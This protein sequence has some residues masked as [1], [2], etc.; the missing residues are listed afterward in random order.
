[1]GNTFG[2]NEVNE[3]NELGESTKP[4]IDF[5]NMEE[6]DDRPE[7]YESFGKS[8]AETEH[9]S[10]LREAEEN[11]DDCAAKAEK[12]DGRRD[13]ADDRLRDAS[14]DGQYV[15]EVTYQYDGSEVSDGEARD[16]VQDAYDN[17]DDPEDM[18]QLKENAEAG[19][20]VEVIDAK[21][22]ERPEVTEGREELAQAEQ[23]SAEAHEELDAA[24]EELARQQE[25][26]AQDEAQEQA[27]AQQ[28]EVRR[29]QT[30][31]ATDES[32]ENVEDPAETGEKAD[33]EGI[34]DEKDTESNEHITD[35]EHVSD[36]AGEGVQNAEGSE[37][38]D[39]EVGEGEGDAEGDERGDGE[40]GE[41]EG[42]A[43]GDE[44]ADGEV[45]EDERDAEGDERGDG[46]VGEGD[47][48]ADGEVGESERDAEGDERGD[49]EVGESERDAEGD[50]RAD[51]EVGEGERDA[52]G[53]ER[54]DGEVGE[55]E[56]DAEG[57][58]RGDGEVGEGERD[59]EGDERGDGEVGEGERDAE[60]DERGD[61]EVGEGE[62]DAEGENDEKTAEN[63]EKENTDGINGEKNTESSPSID[64]IGQAEKAE[65]E[66][67]GDTPTENEGRREGTDEIADDKEQMQK[68]GDAEGSESAER[69][70]EKAGEGT[71]EKEPTTKAEIDSQRR[72]N[73]VRLAQLRD[74]YAKAQEVSARKFEDA[75][76]KEGE[77]RRAAIGVFNDVKL[78][79]EQIHEQIGALERE[80][81]KLGVKSR[82]VQQR[83]LM[84]GDAALARSGQLIDHANEMDRAF[85]ETYYDAKAHKGDLRQLRE[86]NE[87]AID[88]LTADKEALRR[89]MDAKMDQLG[90]HI[91]QNDMD[92]PTS[93]R[94]PLCQQLTKEYNELKDAYA[95]LDYLSVKLDENSR[96]V[97]ERLGED[98]A[99]ALTRRR[100]MIR[101]VADGTDEPGK[102]NYYPDEVRAREVLS[103]FCRENWERASESERQQAVRQ[104]ADYHAEVLGVENKPGIVFRTMDEGV[105]GGYD[106]KTNIISL[107]KEKMDDPAELADTIAHEY[108]H[109]YQEERAG[110][111]ENVRDLQFSRN[112]RDYL[113]PKDEGAL[114][115]CSMDR[116]QNQLVEAD[117]MAYGRATGDKLREIEQGDADGGRPAVGRETPERAGTAEAAAASAAAAAEIRTEPTDKATESGIDKTQIRETSEGLTAE[118]LNELKGYAK[119]HYDNGRKVGDKIRAFDNY[120]EHNDLEKGHIEKVR[121]QSIEAANAIR[122][123]I[124]RGG[125]GDLYS[126]NIDRRTLEVA[127]IYH[128]TGMDGNS[129]PDDVAKK[130]QQAGEDAVRAAGAGED[131]DKTRKEALED[132]DHALRKNHPT[133]SA[134]HVLQDRDKVEGLGVDANEVALC[135]FVHSKSSSGLKDIG[136]VGGKEGWQAAI[137]NLEKG[138]AKYNAEHPDKEQVRFDKS[139]LVRED[140]SFDEEKLKEM[141]SMAAALRIGDANG[142]DGRSRISQNGRTIDFSLKPIEGVDT[143]VPFGSDKE[144]Y[145]GEVQAAD[146]RIAGEPLDNENDEKGISRMYAVGE[147]NFERLYCETD[148]DGVLTEHIEL[149]DG[150]AFPLSTQTAIGE[151]VGEFESATPLNYRFV[152][153]VGDCD[154]KTRH[155]YEEFAARVM[156]DPKFATKGEKE[157]REKHPE[158][159]DEQLTYKNALRRHGRCIVEVV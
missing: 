105:Y 113:E 154:E 36:E 35:D 128:D 45:G 132:F 96:A 1:M 33:T 80:Q 147:G 139:F 95:R 12:A 130:R 106:D 98:Y 145:Y 125:R 93:H 56:R 109:K 42:D 25:I 104:L 66:N 138:I 122:E 151:R 70:A 118:E 59:A 137:G 67:A 53:D 30:D 7:D 107:N 19:G 121:V 94:D 40:V 51:G 65:K 102:T 31:A 82:A 143:N 88:R 100:A 85:D 27:D 29:E 16:T 8:G 89:A 87:K 43:E 18:Q 124:D 68:A 155:G 77:E 92:I 49:S 4:E 38:A 116:Y 28:D 24:E 111:M 5:G 115:D 123:M 15:A 22:V 11:Y 126:A 3:G 91:T 13:E 58:E 153:H 135:C 158:I 64:D 10:E 20:Q 21:V 103:P 156:Q 47:E 61:G 150:N 76:A 37:N 99:S 63:S 46:E 131:L 48:R 72:A 74:E 129:T 108:R 57:D 142:H 41:G 144:H 86:D 159:T 152:I 81:E 52:E 112:L 90:E 79:E 120:K 97:S 26:A 17:C 50:E 2:G 146:V 83:Q 127:A 119:D 69:S 62:R 54:G 114:D 134:I 157:F 34:N 149:V 136:S 78:R 9:A 60:G 140:G 84:A 55:G 71:A 44:R 14:E 39:G 23:E 73:D 32:E 110:K 141:R 133:A 101:E 117:A 148:K 75:C 6:T